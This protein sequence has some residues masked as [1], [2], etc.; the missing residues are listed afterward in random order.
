MF[1]N[2]FFV[3]EL[4]DL[5]PPL[6]FKNFAETT[7]LFNN[8]RKCYQELSLGHVHTR[9]FI[10]NVEFQKEVLSRIND[11]SR[12]LCLKFVWSSYM[13]TETAPELNFFVKKMDYGQCRDITS[14]INKYNKCFEII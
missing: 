10:L 6:D 12:Q 13:W 8:Y 2:E 4:N 7:K 1:F 11:Q 14:T 5:L 3:K 9:R